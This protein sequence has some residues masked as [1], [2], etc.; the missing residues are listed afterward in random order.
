MKVEERTSQMNG[1]FEYNPICGAECEKD[2]KKNI[3]RHG[4]EI[5]GRFIVD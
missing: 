2:N 1:I 5:F 3:R 4:V